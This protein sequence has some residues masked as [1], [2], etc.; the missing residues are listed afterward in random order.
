MNTICYETTGGAG[1]SR[2]R[3]PA[4]RSWTFPRFKSREVIS[5]GP[6]RLFTA[7]SRFGWSPPRSRFRLLQ[8]GPRSAR[9][10]GALSVDVSV[11]GIVS[12]RV[13]TV[14][15]SAGPAVDHRVPLAGFDADADASPERHDDLSR[16]P[17]MPVRARRRVRP[18]DRKIVRQVTIIHR[19]IRTHVPT[20][21]PP[22]RSPTEL[23][24][25]PAG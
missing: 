11:A 7:H 10:S 18:P 9:A 1:L 13:P 15:A 23:W 19:H 25:E 8:S 6:R 12:R 4:C 5:N 21:R 14:L 24:R 20:G 16:S 2:R 3:L 17:R 22:R